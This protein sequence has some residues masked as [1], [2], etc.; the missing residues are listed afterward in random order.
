MAQNLDLRTVAFPTILNKFKIACM[1]GSFKY[2]DAHICC[3]ESMELLAE[4]FLLLWSPQHPKEDIHISH[5]IVF[6]TFD[7]L[8]QLLTFFSLWYQKE[9]CT[10]AVNS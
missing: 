7:V 10:G 3:T 4:T 9:I 5:Y 1:L 6:I 8:G 2:R